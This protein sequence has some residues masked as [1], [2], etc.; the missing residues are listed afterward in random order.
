MSASHVRNVYSHFLRFSCSVPPS[1][2]C[3]SSSRVA[4]RGS[5]SEF[6][7]RSVWTV[8]WQL[9]RIFVA[10]QRIS[11]ANCAWERLST[12]PG[13]SIPK[14]SL[15]PQCAT[16]PKANRVAIF[17]SA[18]APLLSEA[19]PSRAYIFAS[20]PANETWIFLWICSS[21][22]PPWASS[23]FHAVNPNAPDSEGIIVR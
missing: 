15:N 6:F 8:D 14:P 20:R 22:V 10:S 1:I 19:A 13:K 7:C 2:A 4:R 12:P 9:A 17:R 18:D 23:R 21:E 11:F 3:Y 5:K 16:A